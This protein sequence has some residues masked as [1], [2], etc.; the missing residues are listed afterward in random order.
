MRGELRVIERRDHDE[1][2]D[3]L[4]RSPVENLFLTS[5]MGGPGHLRRRLGRLLAHTDASGAIDA[6]CLDGGTIFVTGSAPAALP[7]FVAELGRFRRASS[8]VGPSFA[9]LGLFVGLSDRY[10]E[11][12]SRCSN[13]RRRQPLMLLDEPVAV[14]G[15]RRVQLLDENV[16]QSYLDASV[17]MYTDEI[18]SSP[19]KYGPGYESFVLERL[20]SGDA[21][22]IVED[23]EVIFK[24]DLG[25][26]YQDQAQLQGVWLRPDLRGRGLAV[27]ALARMLELAQR[28]HPRISLYVNDFNVPA[29]RSYERLGFRAVG[30]LSTIHY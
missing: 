28:E 5:R 7:H 29:V 10:G 16:F 2:M 20:R 6:L 21:Y 1:A 25:P 24:A 15:D 12:W 4:L 26:R 23:G 19:F 8:I 22:G 18:G 13:V 30:S 14:E 11:P 9:A 27:P 3:F 17:E